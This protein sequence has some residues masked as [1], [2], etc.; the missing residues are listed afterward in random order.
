MQASHSLQP[1]TYF[2][3]TGRDVATPFE[4]AADERQRGHLTAVRAGGVG[5]NHGHM[6][7]LA[8]RLIPTGYARCLPTSS[9]NVVIALTSKARSPRRRARAEGV[10]FDHGHMAELANRL[11]PT[12]YAR[13]TQQAI[14][15][16]ARHVG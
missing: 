14:Q 8:N 16:G 9:R 2:P 12:G 7:E 4:R 3:V 6:A 1:S 5:V 11:I 13:R 10:G 15:L